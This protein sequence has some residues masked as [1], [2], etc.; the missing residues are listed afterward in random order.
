MQASIIFRS[1]FARRF[2]FRG[3]VVSRR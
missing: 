3:W 1:F 2:H